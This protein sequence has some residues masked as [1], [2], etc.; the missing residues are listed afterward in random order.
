VKAL[1]VVVVGLVAL[2]GLFGLF[3][4]TGMAANGQYR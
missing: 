1:S 3:L 4:L 2:L